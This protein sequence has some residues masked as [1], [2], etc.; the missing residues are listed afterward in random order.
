MRLL[1][2]GATGFVGRHLLGRLLAEGKNVRALVRNPQKIGLDPA[3]NLELVQ[4]DVTEGAGLDQAM[5]GCDAVVHLVGIIVESGNATFERVHQQGTRNVVQSAKRRNVARFIQMSAVGARAD[6]VSEYQTTKWK[7]EE[8]VRQSG[9]PW[10]I[11]RP[12]LIFGPGD[13]FVTQ[14]L[15]VMRKA[16]LFRPVPG[17]GK[18]RFRPIF[19]DDVTA[20]FAQALG[21]S[22]ATNLT[23]ELGGGDDLSLT[24]V[25]AEI[26]QCADIHKPTI[27][28][29]MPLMM[30]GTAVAQTVLRRPPVTLDQLR[31]LK[32][33]SAC[34][35]GP[36]QR[37]FGLTPI[38]FREG[39][40]T[41]L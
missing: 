18:P 11:L 3:P 27:H 12:S 5:H 17:N 22:S 34:D 23:V 38:G 36:M 35:I 28:V 9:I 4:G 13:G 7:A 30:L 1:L 29:P 2:T 37:I 39:L 25:L 33:G 15:D 40:R 16:P 41:Y 6:G 21:N 31:M 24:E 32:E 20:C 10:C 26:A 14:M 19:I 8:A